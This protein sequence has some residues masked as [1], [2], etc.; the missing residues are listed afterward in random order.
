MIVTGSHLSP[1]FGMGVR[2][3]ESD[4]F[5]IADCIEVLG[6][7]DTPE[8]TAN[9]MGLGLTGF[10]A[11]FGRQRP[12]ILVVLGDRFEMHVAA[13]A[14]L[15][16]H[17]PVAHIH[18]GEITIGAFDDALRHSMTKLSHLHFVSTAEYARRVGQL[19]EE[20][21]RITVSG[22]P[23]LDNL[24]TIPLRGREELERDPGLRLADTFL[25]VTYH[26]A[27]LDMGDPAE[28]A[29]A[30]F[31]AIESTGLPSMV[32][33]PNA[34]PGGQAIRAVVRERA[35]AN[36]LVRWVENLGT[37][38]YFSLM[39]LTAAM[40][41]NSSSGI[42]EAASFGLPVVNVGLRQEGRT[43]GPNVIDVPATENAILRGL[44]TA[45]DPRFK[46]GLNGLTNPYG[47]GHAADRIVD[48]LRDVDLGES[49]LIKR[50]ADAKADGR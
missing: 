48:R 38:A 6:S 30:L 3:I 27:T 8:A 28:Q 17:V 16:F 9:A 37:E 22:A 4:G 42:L 46:A 31:R 21:W 15:P 40:V 32:T 39:A 5:E 47:D 24:R 13:L 45:L 2:T 10:A 20:P 35:A 34:D 50:F 11:Y 25:L 1:E 44:R 14:A 29:R 23:S 41:G 43:H 19:G 12:D 7:S 49:L 26:P 36:P 33:M 18:G